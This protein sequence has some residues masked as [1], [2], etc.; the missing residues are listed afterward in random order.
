LVHRGDVLGSYRVFLGL[1]EDKAHRREVLAELCFVGLIDVQ[2]RFFLN[3]SYPSGHKGFRA[4][5]TVELGDAI[6]WDDAHDVL[7]A[8]AMDI[9]VGPRWYSSYEM[10]CNAVTHYLEK[11]KISAVPY[12]GT[13]E[14]ERAML[15]NTAPLSA[16]EGE[17]FIHALIREREPAFQEHLRS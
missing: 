1:M 14:R 9:A 10:A 15:R 7:Y 8:G 16:E 12:A 2:D 11:E 6:G 3:R 4:R 17:A 5:A 13:T